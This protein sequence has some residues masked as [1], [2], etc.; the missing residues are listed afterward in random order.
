M[1][2]QVIT[3]SPLEDKHHTGPDMKYQKCVLPLF[4]FMCALALAGCAATAPQQ[5]ASTSTGQAGAGEAALGETYAALAASGGKL[6]KL[7]PQASHLKIYAF[8]SGRLARLGH[9]HVLTAPQFTGYFYLPGNVSAAQ[10]DLLFHLDQL[11]LDDPAER[12]LLGPAFAST[13]SAE[14]IAAT[15]EHMLGEDNL[16]AA[17]FPLVR[18]HSLQI[19]GEAPKFAVQVEMELHG[20]TRQ[21]RLPLTVTGLPQQLTV[22]GA[23]VVRQSDFGI[24]PYSVMAGAMSVQ[25]ELVIEFELH[26]K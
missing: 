10:F 11:M 2:F 24:K 6:F 23:L 14:A 22:A 21:M 25:D 26:A 17:Q 12:A 13:V 16:Q 8:R 7:D 5:L 18:I 1:V 15:R 19:A 4:V 20:Q 9:N 3:P